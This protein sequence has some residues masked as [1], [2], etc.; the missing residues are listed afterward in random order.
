MATT[1]VRIDAATHEKLRSLA[2]EMDASMQEV[3]A[4]AV[5][6]YQRTWLLQELNDYYEKLRADPVAWAEEL[7]QRQLW[8]TA[9]MDGLHD[10]PYPLEPDQIA[11]VEAIMAERNRH[12]NAAEQS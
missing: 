3:L 4:K 12:H 6:A 8:D 9:L 11:R 10:D 7:A 5:E 2:C 1:T